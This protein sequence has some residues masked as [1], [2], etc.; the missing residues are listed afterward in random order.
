MFLLLHNLFNL[1]KLSFFNNFE[2]FN[3][4]KNKMVY[5]K[6]NKKALT[7]AKKCKTMFVFHFLNFSILLTYLKQFDNN[8]N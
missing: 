5:Y 4:T 3:N 8:K 7:F 6:S 2:I 1:V